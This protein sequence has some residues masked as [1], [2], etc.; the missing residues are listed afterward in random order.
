MSRALPNAV[1]E[2]AFNQLGILNPTLEADMPA[3]INAGLQRLY[4]YQH[5]DGGWGWWF[6][7]H[8][9]LPDRWVIFGL[10]LPLRQATRSSR[11]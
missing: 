6:D 3:L 1:I 7:T 10:V 2:L 9:R 4:G 5:T 8:Q 11:R